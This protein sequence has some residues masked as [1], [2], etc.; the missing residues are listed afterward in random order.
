[1]AL[2]ARYITDKMPENYHFLGLIHLMLPN[3]KIIHCMRDPMDTCFSCYS[4]SFAYGNEYSYDL[5]TLGRHYQRYAK[6]MRH[7]RSVLPPDRILDM[8]YE[9]NLADPERHAR[10]MLDYLG[11][12]WD[13]TCLRFHET[14]R[15]VRTASVMQVRQP[16]YLSSVGRWKRFEKQ[17]ST[18]L[19]KIGDLQRAYWDEVGE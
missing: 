3:A 14:I 18:L 17:L 12:P 1:V 2:D 6:L 13:S 10:R 11:I 4:Q 15:P 8:R 16:I 5:Q 19:D 7:W 9:D